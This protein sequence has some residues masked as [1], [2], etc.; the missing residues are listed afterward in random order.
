MGVTK[1]VFSWSSWARLMVHYSFALQL[2]KQ[3]VEEYSFDVGYKDQRLPK[4]SHKWVEPEVE[5][6]VKHPH[7]LFIYIIKKI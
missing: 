3:K 7:L 6:E 4:A 1:V 2:I 5:P